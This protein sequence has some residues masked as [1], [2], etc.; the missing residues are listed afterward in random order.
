MR[1]ELRE[2]RMART[3]ERLQPL[4]AA[5]H[6]QAE[7]LLVTQV[8]FKGEYEKKLQEKQLTAQEAQLH[9]AAAQVEE[10]KKQVELYRTG[11]DAAVQE[12]LVDWDG[13]IQARYA[14]GQQKIVEVQARARYY[15][16]TRRAEADADASRKVAE[17]ERALAQVEAQKTELVNKTYGTTGGRLMLARHAAENL[18][19]RSVTLNSNDPRVPSILDIDE[20]AQRLLGEPR[21]VPRP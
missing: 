10:A 18:N 15:D 17:G 4:L 16:K 21:G 11:T 14:E 19:I 8:L 20:L 3:L 13:R 2:Q 7:S 6:T 12:L 9:R 1:T 5:F